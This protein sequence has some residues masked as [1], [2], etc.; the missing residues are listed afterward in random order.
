MIYYMRWGI[1]FYKPRLKKEG[2]LIKS[3][4]QKSSFS[5]KR[6]SKVALAFVLAFLLV[7]TGVIGNAVA[8]KLD[9]GIKNE[10]EQQASQYLMQSISY[11]NES[12]FQRARHVIKDQFAF[13]DKYS[14]YQ[15]YYDRAEILIVQGKYQEAIY[16]LDLSYMAVKNIGGDI[17]ETTDDIWVKKGCLYALMNDYDGAIESFANVSDD[18][19][20]LEDVIVI[21]T[22]IYLEEGDSQSAEQLLENYLAENEDVTLRQTLAEIYYMEADYEAAAQNYSVLLQKTSQN[23][24]MY[25]MMRGICF[26][27]V[28]GYENAI[29]DYESAIENG[30]ED[31]SMCY[32]HTALSY[33][34]LGDDNKVLDYGTRAAEDASE[35]V[36][37]YSLYRVMGLSCLRLGEYQKGIEKF[38]LAQEG[39]ESLESIYY[40]RGVCHMALSQFEMAAEDFTRSIDRGEQTALS[41]Y[42]RGI[43]YLQAG[44]TEESKRDFLMVLDSDCDDELKASAQVLIDSIG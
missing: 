16:Q 6:L 4:D 30:Y 26:E 37:I 25:Y 31:T 7:A 20:F 38:T 36:E 40:Y 1:W 39:D 12:I 5:L 33:Y 3:M 41:C 34:M 23:S 44:S 29:S 8:V 27:Q 22:Q 42:N 2:L 28:G 17:T 24:G 11:A 10:A 21:E 19:V 14:S 32:E 35:Q 18:S 15:D 13:I 9:N 43:C